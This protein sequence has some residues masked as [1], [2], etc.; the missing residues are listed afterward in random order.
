MRILIV[1]DAWRPQ[2][3][4]VVK[5]LE[6]TITQLHLMGHEVQVASPQADRWGT[7]AAPS[8]HSIK[9]EFFA[10]NRLKNI[11]KSYNPEY[12]HIA[13]EGP[14]GWSARNACMALHKPFTTSFHTR[15]P[16]YLAA[17]VPP[18]L[19]QPIKL[20]SYAV[21]R[22]FHAP[23]SAV[24]VATASIEKELQRRR[25]RRLVR[26]SRGVDT[27]IFKPDTKNFEPY[28]N[29]P[30]PIL[31]YV[32]RVAVEKNL[33]AFLSSPAAGTKVVIGDG[34]DLEILKRNYP[35][36]IF[37]GPME[38]EILARHYAAADLF[39]FPSKTDTF[40]LVLLE[41]A[42]T[43][44]RIASYPAS[45]PAD[46]FSDPATRNFAILDA[47]LDHAIQ[48]ALALPDN[49][50]APR[51]F[52]E[53][54]SWETCTWQFFRHLQAPTPQAIKRITR[55]RN[56]LSRSWQRALAFAFK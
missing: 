26:W 44:L 3:N 39:V 35:S 2:L 48:Q 1:S 34:P 27:N 8:Y 23:S 7:V 40:G 29:F 37:L 32:G 55:L 21:L 38:N 41:A 28:T 17:R 24:M 43:G 52:A 15:F 6:A 25:F 31:L 36:A 20:I 50:S 18:P 56:W 12:I 33:Q 42:A 30:R 54:F 14:L 10:R 4:G 16:D 45:G 51:Q 9:L 49:P 46:I 11:I 47:D 19:R 53:T 13:T 22:R 5:T